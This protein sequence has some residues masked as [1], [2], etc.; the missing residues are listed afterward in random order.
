MKFLKS[1]FSVLMV[2]LLIN[3][4][5]QSCASIDGN[6]EVYSSNLADDFFLR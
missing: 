1:K 4:S 3:L 5:A 2:F 6:A